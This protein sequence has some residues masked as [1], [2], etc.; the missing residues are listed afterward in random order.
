MGAA[1]VEDSTS[2]ALDIMTMEET[3][4]V[5]CLSTEKKTRKTITCTLAIKTFRWQVMVV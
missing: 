2:I 5:A 4:P 1:V 3:Y